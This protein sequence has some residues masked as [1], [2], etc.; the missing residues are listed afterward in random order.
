[1][2]HGCADALA[3]S[4]DVVPG[5]ADA[6]EVLERFLLDVFGFFVEG[7][8]EVV[9]VVVVEEDRVEVVVVGVVALEFVVG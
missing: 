2:L 7:Q 1:M 9:E 6:Y 3:Q 8:V 4:E 5:A